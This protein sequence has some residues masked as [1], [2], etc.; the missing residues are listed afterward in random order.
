MGL[1][2]GFLGGLGA[3]LHQEKSSQ[4]LHTLSLSRVSRKIQSVWAKGSG[5]GGV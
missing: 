4:E 3:E 1:W 5:V 2:P